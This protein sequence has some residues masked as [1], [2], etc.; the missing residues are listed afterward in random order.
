VESEQ[1]DFYKKFSA[2]LSLRE[3]SE[4]YELERKLNVDKYAA[5]IAAK[6]VTEFTQSFLRDIVSHQM[7]RRLPD[8]IYYQI[9][10]DIVTEVV[11]EAKEIVPLS[12]AEL[13]LVDMIFKGGRGDEVLAQAFNVDMTREKMKCLRDHQWLNDEVLIVD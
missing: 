10:K 5:P 7:M 6:L 3:K 13:Q 8:S 12:A 11:E 9:L 4:E 1:D 2:V